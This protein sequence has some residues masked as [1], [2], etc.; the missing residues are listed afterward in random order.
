[1]TLEQFENRLKTLAACA[2]CDESDELFNEEYKLLLDDV[3]KT[4]A[5]AR[6]AYAARLRRLADIQL[7]WTMIRYMRFR[8]IEGM[9]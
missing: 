2:E 5:P 6:Q 1:M 7:A 8:R 9:I 4:E 3:S